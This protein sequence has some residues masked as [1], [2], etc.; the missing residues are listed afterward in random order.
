MKTCSLF[1]LLLIALSITPALAQESNAKKYHR[2]AASDLPLDTN[3][4]SIVQRFLRTNDQLTGATNEQELMRNA[5]HLDRMIEHINS[6]KQIERLVPADDRPKVIQ[7]QQQME[8]LLSQR[9]RQH[10]IHNEYVIMNHNFDNAMRW[11]E[12]FK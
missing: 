10:R 5:W 4:D 8:K 7:L 3:L 1:A 11:L 2:T 6:V 12:I 9:L